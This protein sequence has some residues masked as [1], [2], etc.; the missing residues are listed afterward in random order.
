[1][2]KV[3]FESTST[4]TVV[5]MVRNQIAPAFFPQSYVEPDAPMV[6][7]SIAPSLEWT[8]TVTT[9]KG[10][11]LNRAELELVELSR[12]YHLQQ[13]HFD[14]CLEGDRRQT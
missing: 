12:E 10:A 3:L 1:M 13:A 2:P 6:Y 8:L 7:F 5:N 4:Q 14:Y 11:Y 9:Q